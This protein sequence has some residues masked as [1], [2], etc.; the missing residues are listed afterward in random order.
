MS[1]KE[2]KKRKE[3]ERG[4]GVGDKPFTANL[5]MHMI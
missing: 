2:E 3:K 4:A 5:A 1:Q